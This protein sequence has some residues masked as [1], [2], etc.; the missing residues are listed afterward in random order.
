MLIL[1]DAD[2]PRARELHLNGE[3]NSKS[4][5]NWAHVF[6]KV[7]TRYHYLTQGTPRA[8][9]TLPLAK[10]FILPGW[11]RNY[12]I[13]PWQR[14]LRFEES[15]APFHY[16]DTL[17][18]YDEGLLILPSTKLQAYALY[19]LEAGTMVGIDIGSHA[20]VVRRISLK[21]KV[22]LVEWC[23]H[24]SYHQLNENET[25]YRHFATAFDVVQ[26][27]NSQAWNVVFRLVSHPKLSTLR[28]WLI[29]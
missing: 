27:R 21:D 6:T 25:V 24:Q 26:D 29:A 11:C 10:S 14:H 8:V 4:D 17:W 12:P 13:T 16:P 7:A 19:D 23:E 3:V 2:Y 5:L 1:V 18:T 20:K 15:T 28:A 9:E 22:L